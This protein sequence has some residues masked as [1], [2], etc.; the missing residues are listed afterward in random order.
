MIKIGDIYAWRG[1]ELQILGVKSD[2][3]QACI[4]K[5]ANAG[6]VKHQHLPL[7][8]PDDARYIGTFPVIESA[9]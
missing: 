5:R 9:L 6:Q 2:G 4:K 1:H 3:T 8:L 7:P